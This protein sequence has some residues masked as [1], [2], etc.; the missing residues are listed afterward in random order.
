MGCGCEGREEVCV[1]DVYTPNLD[2][3]AAE[4]AK[5]DDATEQIAKRV[6]HIE[7]E[8][9]SEALRA[10]VDFIHDDGWSLA[11]VDR[12]GELHHSWG[13]VS[14]TCLDACAE[15]KDEPLPFGCRGVPVGVTGHVLCGSVATRE[16]NNPLT[17]FGAT[18]T[19]E[20]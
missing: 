13:I 15:A 14:E 7:S 4:V 11:V 3:I 19:I 20:R 5:I 2:R 17:G 18:A 6:H 16:T 1:P 10:A 12:S 8:I 9:Q